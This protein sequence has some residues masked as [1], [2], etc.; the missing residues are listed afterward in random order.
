MGAL[1]E[2]HPSVVLKRPG[3]ELQVTQGHRE[4]LLGRDDPTTC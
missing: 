2:S 1:E 4:R 3:R